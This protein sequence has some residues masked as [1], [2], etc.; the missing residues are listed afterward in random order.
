[1][2]HLTHL[3][4]QFVPWQQHTHYWQ[5]SYR[6]HQ[7]VG[8]TCA[9]AIRRSSSR[10][11][12]ARSAFIVARCLSS[13]RT[14]TASA[15]A[16]RS[17]SVSFFS[18]MCALPGLARL[19][20]LLRR[21]PALPGGRARPRGGGCGLA[22]V[23]GLGHRAEAVPLLLLLGGQ[24]LPVLHRGREG[25]R[26]VCPGRKP[27]LLAFKRRKPPL[28]AVKRPARPRKNAIERVLL[29]RTLWACSRRGRARTHV[30]LPR[31]VLQRLD[32]GLHVEVVGGG[33]AGRLLGLALA[34]RPPLLRRRLLLLLLRRLL[35]LRPLL[36]PGT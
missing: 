24:V 1:V 27:P 25:V 4:Y 7:Y 18:A 22:L 17:A 34:L 29:W 12:A 26:V 30:A 10:C 11:C 16:N 33:R 3:T 20:R 6:G 19:R 28:L 2:H 23:L 32:L 8:G 5:P 36:W 9:P 15:A 31:R 14:A 13:A 21:R 35:R